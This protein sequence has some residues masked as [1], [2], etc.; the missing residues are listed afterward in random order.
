MTKGESLEWNGKQ[1]IQLKTKIQG[2]N[3]AFLKLD[4]SPCYFRL[5]I[6]MCCLDSV[7]PL[8][9]L[10]RDLSPFVYKRLGEDT[11]RNHCNNLHLPETLGWK[12]SWEKFFVMLFL[13]HCRVSCASKLHFESWSPLLNPLATCLCV[14]FRLPLLFSSLP[15]YL[16]TQPCLVFLLIGGGRGSRFKGCLSIWTRAGG[17]DQR[18]GHRDMPD[19][20]G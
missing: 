13:R 11:W 20:T 19:W 8:R 14:L 1:K 7:D 18:G 12:Q 6:N 16:H 15:L 2:E 5:K 10:Q 3:V 4:F 9:L 17:R